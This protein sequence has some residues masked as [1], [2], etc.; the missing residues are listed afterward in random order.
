LSQ[1]DW[2]HPSVD[3]QARLAEIAYRTVTAREAPS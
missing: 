3:G 1:W 2:F